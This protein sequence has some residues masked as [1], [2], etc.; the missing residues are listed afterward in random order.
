MALVTG[1]AMLPE[2]MP[3]SIL[4]GLVGLLCCHCL[5]ALQYAVVAGIG[6]G[7]SF[8]LVCVP[9]LLKDAISVLCAYAAALAVRKALQR[10][11][12]AV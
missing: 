4:G 3:L 1:L 5:G 12:L 8:M 10:A 2:K 11:G 7:E 6:F 9:Y